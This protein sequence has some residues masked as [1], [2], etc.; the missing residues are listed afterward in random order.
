MNAEK[1]G[2]N[3][4]EPKIEQ[5]FEEVSLEESP[6]G[7]KKKRR[8][9]SF[10]HALGEAASRWLKSQEKEK[11]SKRKSYRIKTE[12]SVGESH[13]VPKQ[14][15]LER[16]KDRL[17][18]ATHKVERKTQSTSSLPEQ[19]TPPAGHTTSDKELPQQSR[20][21]SRSNKIPRFVKNL[22][23]S[24][25][26]RIKRINKHDSEKSLDYKQANKEHS[27]QESSRDSDKNSEQLNRETASEKRVIYAEKSYS[28]LVTSLFVASF[29]RE[30][31]RRKKTHKEI[32][33]LREQTNRLEG[34]RRRQ[35]SRLYDLRSEISQLQV[36]VKE[37]VIYKRGEEVHGEYEGVVFNRKEDKLTF[38]EKRSDEKKSLELRQDIIPSKKDI[39]PEKLAKKT[40][41]QKIKTESR[42][43]YDTESRQAPIRSFWF[44]RLT[45]ERDRENHSQRII[46]RIQVAREKIDSIKE[47]YLTANDDIETKRNTK[48]AHNQSMGYGAYRR[49]APKIVEQSKA[50]YQRVK[51]S[52]QKS[53]NPLRE[54]IER[55]V[56]TTSTVSF[57]GNLLIVIG[58][59]LLVALIIRELL[60]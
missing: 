36:R 54:E 60:I 16:L 9:K 10:F 38:K 37:A 8:K 30:R 4:E 13:E 45:S 17:S 50:A 44:D 12:S 32:G 58:F 27:S 51:E 19:V 53:V 3:Q 25:T 31:R 52:S 14:T 48:E 2:F 24:F 41:V 55:K 56:S 34:D 33:A 59:I 57:I 39:Q 20:Q 5:S 43:T 7:E 26:E 46:N 15:L 28:P 47:G 35:E 29:I 40:I 1:G 21:S 42:N 23:T 18:R 49:V 22:K 11:E 6:K